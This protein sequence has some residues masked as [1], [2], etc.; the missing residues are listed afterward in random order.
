M[1][2]YTREKGDNRAVVISTHSSVPH[3]KSLSRRHT[4]WFYTPIAVNLIARKS[5]AIFATDRCG[6]TCRLILADR[7]DVARQ[8]CSR[9]PSR[10]VLKSHVIK[11]PNPI[12]RLYWRFAAMSVENRGDG[13]IWR[14]P[15]NLI[16][17]I[18]HAR[19]RRFYTPIPAIGENCNRCTGHTWRFSL[20]G[21]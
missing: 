6:H 5:Q 14:M 4:W 13:H 16:A 20:I 10:S 19:Y 3:L 21:I 8:P 1:Y 11:S 12:S 2:F 17:D 7:D 15:A 18:W 9:A